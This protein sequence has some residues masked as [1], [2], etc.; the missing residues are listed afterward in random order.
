MSMTPREQLAS[1]T[2]IAT[3]EIVVNLEKAKSSLESLINGMQDL[4]CLITT[5]GRIIWGNQRAASWLG[6]DHDLVHLCFMKQLF[7]DEDWQQFLARLEP[8]LVS[9]LSGQASEFQSPIQQGE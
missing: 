7:K 5:D 4:T 2:M 3:H 6:I 9:G 8:Y 1:A